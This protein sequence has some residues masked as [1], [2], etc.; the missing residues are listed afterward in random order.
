MN[1]AVQRDLSKIWRFAAARRSARLLHAEKLVTGQSA[2]SIY[3]A[4]VARLHIADGKPADKAAAKALLKEAA[5]MGHPRAQATLGR[6]EYEEMEALRA[7]SQVHDYQAAAE[8]HKWLRQA[9][10]QGELDATRTLIPLYVT[11]G[12]LAAAGRTCF[13]LMW[14]RWRRLLG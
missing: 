11:R 14:M 5:T 8:A 1:G 3:E 2:D 4:G 9:S 13:V 7:I 12:D 10:E 6:L